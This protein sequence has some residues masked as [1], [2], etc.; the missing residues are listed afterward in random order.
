MRALTAADAAYKRGVSTVEHAMAGW[1]VVCPQPRAE[2]PAVFSERISVRARSV[3][4]IRRDRLGCNGAH[5]N[6]G[7]GEIG[8]PMK[9]A[10]FLTLTTAFTAFA[11]D[12]PLGQA[13]DKN[14]SGVEK[15]FVSLAEAMPANAYNFAP[16]AGELKGVR[17][18]AQQAKHV[19]AVNY[20][21]GSC[22]SW[23]EA[24]ERYWRRN[25]PD[26]SQPKSRSSPS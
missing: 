7:K 20:L 3:D 8:I 2:D 4:L 13:F 14:L 23:R 16:T 19:A 17:T 5:P 18:F 9:Y 26:P 1:L 12:A 11:A 10:A 22:D 21:I 6:D 15:E 25:G 24:A